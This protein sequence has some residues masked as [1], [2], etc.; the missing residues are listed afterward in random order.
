VLLRENTHEELPGQLVHWQ[1]TPFGFEIAEP[2]GLAYTLGS[3]AIVLS[4]I[5]LMITAAVAFRSLPR[6]I[7]VMDSVGIGLGLLLLVVF[8]LV[9]V[10]GSHGI[11]ADSELLRRAKVREVET[12]LS[13]IWRFAQTRTV[14]HREL[15]GAR[16]Y[17]GLGHLIAS[18]K[19]KNEGG[20]Y[21]ISSGPGDRG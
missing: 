20:C 18:F 19:P 16:S 3:V 17:V 8:Y 10:M 11:A 14:H 21:G 5:G 6:A 13:G 15:R 2:I 9:G 7:A 1:R 4:A 12:T